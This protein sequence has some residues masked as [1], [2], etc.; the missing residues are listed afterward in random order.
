MHR[1]LR[2]VIPLLL[3][4]ACAGVRPAVAQQIDLSG[5]WGVTYFEDILHRGATLVPGDNTGVPLSEAGRRKA[6][7]WDE[8]VVATHERQCVP[9]TVQYAVRGPGNIRFAKVVDQE[10]G[11]LI[12]Y[13]LQGS[14]VGHFRTIW[15]DGRPHPSELARHSYTGF[16]TGRWERNMLVVNTTHMKMGYLDRNGMPS[17]EL[18]KMTEYFLRHGDRLTAVTFIHD[19]VFLNAPFVRT[20]DFVYNPTGNAGNWGVCAPDQIVDELFDKPRGYVPH[21][22]PGAADPNRELFLTS[23]QVPLE[24]ARGGTAT[25]FPEYAAKLKDMPRAGS[26]ARAAPS[27]DGP[28][29]GG[30]RCA[31]VPGATLGEIQVEHV[32]GKVYMLA[33]AGANIAVQVGDDGVLLVNSGSA[34]VADK[35]LE[36]VRKLAPDKPIRFVLNTGAH[37]DVMGANGA[38]AK[39][40]NR[41][42]GRGQGAGASVIAHEGVLTALSTSTGRSAALAEIPTESWPTMTYLLGGLKDVYTNGEAIQMHHK[43]AAHSNGDS[44]VLFRGS[45]VLLTGQIVDF[46]RYPMI[47]AS[48]GGTFSGLLNAVNDIIDLTVPRDWQEAGTL[49][50]A[51]RGHIGDESD[52]VEYRD[53]LTIIRD[54]VR[55]MIKKGMSLEQVQAARPTFEYDGLYGATTGPWTTAMFVEAVYRDLSKPARPSSTN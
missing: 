33:G 50:I 53:M 36:A 35:V 23:R 24:A 41:S 2:I 14:Y 18:G 34:K 7:S 43:P 49:V 9:H 19:P 44:V 10:T 8:S 26:G 31:P 16:S 46:T 52:V 47:D 38:I 37:P 55:D 13:S 5:E 11:R 54:R 39:A 1:P 48:Q 6:E 22:L 40:G 32:Q 21:H 28:A 30:N 51:A 20:T 3:C 15:M 25:T 4:L 27:T 17:S 29:C 45:D 12:A 42:S